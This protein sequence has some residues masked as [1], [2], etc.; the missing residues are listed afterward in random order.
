MLASAAPSLRSASAQNVHRPVC[1]SVVSA[2]AGHTRIEK[3]PR[4]SAMTEP[5]CLHLLAA[6]RIGSAQA[7][8]EISIRS[9]IRKPG[10]KLQPTVKLTS[11]NKSYGTSGTEDA[12]AQICT[13]TRICIVDHATTRATHLPIRK[14][15]RIY[16]AE[17]ANLGLP[18]TGTSAI[19]FNA[20][21]SMCFALGTTIATCF[22]PASRTCGCAV[23]GL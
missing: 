14:Y 13:A 12:V 18:A 22:S 7:G 4:A 20:E 17:M 23:D 9:V 10:R 19:R 6:A 8:Q 16:A 2:H 3:R 21:M 11:R 1:D 5:Q 15:W